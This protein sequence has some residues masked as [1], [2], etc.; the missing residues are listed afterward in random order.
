MAVEALKR[1][2]PTST[3]GR[4]VVALFQND[5]RTKG[6]ER[7]ILVTLGR[8]SEPARRAAIVATPTVD[9][10]D[11]ARLCDL[12][13]EQEIGVKRLPRVDAAWFD[14]FD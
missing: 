3:L 4:E 7:A 1:Y 5:A 2:D 9:L 11:G 10:I 13:L 6:A 12:V 14:R 8:F